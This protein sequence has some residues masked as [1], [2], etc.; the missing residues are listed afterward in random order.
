LCND[1]YIM[2]IQV[3]GPL[4]A[5]LAVLD[6][7]PSDA[8][9]PPVRTLSTRLMSSTGSL[10]LWHR[11]LSHLSTTTVA[12]M[13]DED[14]VTGMTITD[15]EPREHPCE[16]CLEGKQTCEAIR[17][18]AASCADHALG[19]V[20]SDVC[21]PL[22]TLS[23]KGFKYFVTFVDD[24]THYVSISPL[25]EKSEVGKHL[26]AFV[27][28]AKLDT[29]RKVK[30]LRSNGGGEYT[31]GH[32]RDFLEER[33]ISHEMMTANT[34]QHNGVVERLNRTLLNHVRAM[35]S[36]AKLPDSYW[37]E[38]LNYAILLHNVS[39]TAALTMTPAEAYSGTKL[40][41]LRLHVFSCMAHAHVPEHSRT[42]LSARSLPCT[43]LSFAPHRSTFRLMHR[44]TRKFIESHDV[45]FDEGD[46][47]LRHERIILE[48]DNT[49]NDTPPV[50][51]GT[52]TPII[53]TSVTPDAPPSLCPKHA[54]RPP[55]PDD[56]PR[57]D[58]SSYYCAAI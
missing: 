20:F 31:T 37:L 42:K 14:L 17:K 9:L 28:K 45:V 44:P 38:A 35:L 22:P 41:V 49:V 16:P 30:I 7:Q 53:S 15:R 18:E 54:T 52:P 13:A 1:L 29:G 34:P 50:N 4:T 36:D 10:D 2:R 5:R 19:R 26:K 46:P 40:D 57:Y 43:F 25:K 24:K 8:S 12:C 33:G 21:G 48:P 3:N 32:V 47:T 56:N 51:V 27:L 55:V 11:R 39:P 58:I 23:H 6:S